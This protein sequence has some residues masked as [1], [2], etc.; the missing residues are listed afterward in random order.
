[1][2]KRFLSTKVR[3]I[4]VTAA[5]VATLAVAVAPAAVVSNLAAECDKHACSVGLR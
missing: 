4:L 1:M 2:K 5:A 3:P